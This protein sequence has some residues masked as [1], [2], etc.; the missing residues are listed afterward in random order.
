MPAELPMGSAES[1]K[2]LGGAVQGVTARGVGGTAHAVVGAARGCR[3][4]CPWVRLSRL[5]WSAEPPKGVVGAP[6]VSA[7]PPPAVKMTRHPTHVAMRT[8]VLARRLGRR[9]HLRRPQAQARRYPSMGIRQR[10]LP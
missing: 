4:S 5:R 8:L 7:E 6:H 3:Q 1:T 9:L 10:R 2:G